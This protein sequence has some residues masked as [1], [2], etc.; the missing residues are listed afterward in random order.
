MSSQP[1]TLEHG[2]LLLER[3]IIALAAAE[4]IFEIVVVLVIG[5]RLFGMNVALGI[6]LAIDTQGAWAGRWDARR[7]AVAGKV[8]LLEDLDKRVFAMA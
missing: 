5:I 4:P 1:K 3:V 8:S 2:S 7:S 6:G